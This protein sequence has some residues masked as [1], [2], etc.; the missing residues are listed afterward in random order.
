VVHAI[1]EGLQRPARRHVRRRDAEQVH[2]LARRDQGRF[3]L[4]RD[5]DV[6]TR[7][8]NPQERRVRRRIARDVAD[9]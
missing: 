3:A 5:T 4:R 9:P 6:D 7:M 1:V 2:A 8:R